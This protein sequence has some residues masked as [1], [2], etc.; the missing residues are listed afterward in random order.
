MER[1]LLTQRGQ[2]IYAKRGQTIE[3]IFGQLK[4]CLGYRNFLLRGLKKV[5]G[6][7]DLQCAVS[8]MLKLLRLSGATTSQ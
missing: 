2:R 8:N 1:K 6:E 7:W 5:Q 4:E 3:A